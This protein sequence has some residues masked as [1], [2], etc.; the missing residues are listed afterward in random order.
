MM[1]TRFRLRLQIKTTEQMRLRCRRRTPY[2]TDMSTRGLLRKRTTMPAIHFP[3]ATAR[4]TH[5][6]PQTTTRRLR[7]RHEQT[8]SVTVYTT[9]SS[10]R[11]TGTRTSRH[12][13][14]TNRRRT[15]RSV[16]EA[17]TASGI[18]EIQ[19]DSGLM[20]LAAASSADS[21]PAGYLRDAASSASDRVADGSAIANSD[22]VT[23]AKS[24]LYEYDDS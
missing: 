23:A 1:Q 3:R 13:G 22:T 4:Q 2:R 18:E 12:I 21:P 9:W 14:S 10:R 19:V 8:V 20:R 17:P 6:R 5:S 15:S 11:T 16:S 7:R 24:T